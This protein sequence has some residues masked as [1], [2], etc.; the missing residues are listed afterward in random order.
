MIKGGTLT[1]IGR[2]VMS[3]SCDR[4]RSITWGVDG[5]LPEHTSRRNAQAGGRATAVPRR[6]FLRRS[7]R[8]QATALSVPRPEAVV[9]ETH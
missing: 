7:G 8:L 6:G 9:L 3:Y 1:E 5:G 2:T 4:A